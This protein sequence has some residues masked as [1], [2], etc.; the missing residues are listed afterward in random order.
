VRGDPAAD[1]HA[2]GGKL[3]RDRRA[4]ISGIVALNPNTG[5]SGHA[6][7]GYAETRCCADHA[8]LELPHVPHNVAADSVQIENGITD[9]LARSMIGNIATAIRMMK[10]HTRLAQK[11][12]GD[13]QVLAVAASAKSDDVGM[14]AEEQEIGRSS[15]LARGDEALLERG[16]FA[17]S[18]PAEINRFAA[19]HAYP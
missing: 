19:F 5:A 1:V 4:A 12:L 13:V 2:N 17:V 8:F 7:R 11:V 3:F 10:F 6:E 15:D 14:F 18:D 9:D 16:G